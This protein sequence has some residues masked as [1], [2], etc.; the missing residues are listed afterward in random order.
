VDPR[1]GL[2]TVE[3]RENLLPMQKIEPSFLNSPDHSLVTVLTQLSLL[4]TLQYAPSARNKKYWCVKSM[5]K[6][7]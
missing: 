7:C 4:T 3:K 5:K 1:A 6:I 2:G